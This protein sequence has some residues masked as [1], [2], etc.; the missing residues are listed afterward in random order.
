MESSARPLDTSAAVRTIAGVVDNVGH[1][2][3]AER[4]TRT[5][6]VLASEWPVPAGERSA[7]A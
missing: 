6:R 3:H 2:I 7:D 4:D 1:V 5:N